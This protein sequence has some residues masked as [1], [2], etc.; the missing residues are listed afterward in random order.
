MEETKKNVLFGI[1]NKVLEMT[2]AETAGV[3]LSEENNTFINYAACVGK[4][5]EALT[6]RKGPAAGSGLCGTT[7]E[8]GEPV[9][10]CQTVGDNRVRQDHVKAFGITTA[11]AVPVF[12]EGES[13]AVLMAMNRPDGSPF[14]EADEKRLNEYAPTV[15]KTIA[16]YVKETAS[17]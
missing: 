11:L 5:G 9:L 10:V 4:L 12:Y 13:I 6:G 1:A 15:A 7:L 14:S 8:A 17:V 16:D 3:V 2:G